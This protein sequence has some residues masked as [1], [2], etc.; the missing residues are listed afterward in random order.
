VRED[1]ARDA[2]QRAAE[3]VKDVT[4]RLQREV[5]ALNEITEKYAKQ[6]RDARNRRVQILRLRLHVK[7][8][9]LHYMQAIWAFESHD[10][11]FLRLHQVTT[12]TFTDSG[13]EYQFAGTVEGTRVFGRRD[14]SSSRAGP[15]SSRCS[16]GSRCPRTSCRWKRSRT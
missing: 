1:A 11:R 3:Q 14:G 4:I 6:L 2:E 12:P 15:T 9:I 5:T 16:R 7:M 13:T 8:Y 10:Q